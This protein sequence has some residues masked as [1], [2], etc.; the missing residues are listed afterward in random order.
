MKKEE[1]QRFNHYNLFQITYLS[2]EN[3]YKFRIFM[4]EGVLLK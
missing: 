4:T 3:L 2:I 1:M